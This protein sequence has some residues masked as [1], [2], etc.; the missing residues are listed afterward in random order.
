VRIIGGAWR[1][2]KVAVADVPGLRPTPDRVRE[3]LFNWLAPRL[4][5]AKVLDCCAG[6][7]VLGLEAASRGAAQLVLIEQHRPAAE[8]IQDSAKRLGANRVEIR[9]GDVLQ[10]LATVDGCF[11]LV[12]IDPPYALP[13]LRDSIL[14]KLIEYEL[15]QEGAW[16]YLEWPLA[17]GF[18][19]KHP[20]LTWIK[21]KTAGALGYAI[22]QWR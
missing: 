19:L 10:V 9:Q 3:T 13:T 6:S 15:L 22:A 20:D 7:G 11:D 12:F 5:N 14:D 17:E 18:K 21:Q 1:G 8:L 16:L 2:S 4:R